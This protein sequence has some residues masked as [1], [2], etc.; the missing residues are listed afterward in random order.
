MNAAVAGVP[1]LR[2]VLA[3]HPELLRPLLAQFLDPRLGVA[4]RHRAFAHDLTFTA[5]RLDAAYAG[6]FPHGRTAE[7]W[8]DERNGW[9][10]AIELNLQSPQEGLWRLALLAPDGMRVF[11]LCFSVLNGP[12]LF[13]GA[14]QGGTVG[15]RCGALEHI[16][17]AT[18]DLEGLRP[19]FL[20]VEA[21]RA[22]GAC[23]QIER[24][25]GIG[26]AHQ[27]KTWAK[28][29]ARAEIRFDYD[30]FFQDLGGARRP[31]G[32]WDVPPV[33]AERR[34]EDVP[35]RKRAMYRRRFGLLR[36]LRASV[37]ERLVRD[38]VV[39]SSIRYCDT[40]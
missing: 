17:A 20:L 10:V 38:G 25:T 13:L 3:A 8:R 9:S 35:S 30:R 5:P 15:A 14:V 16:Q 21:L 31:D 27:P 28:R 18:R 19:A 40:V 6:F 4:A 37:G 11:S 2:Q 24:F 22:V 29:R 32:N 7:L 34:R 23:W 1:A 33:A 39:A 12:E 26:A 36:A